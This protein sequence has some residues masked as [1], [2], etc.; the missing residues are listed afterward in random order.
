MYKSIKIHCDI[1]FKKYFDARIREYQI[2]TMGNEY[3]SGETKY[4]ENYKV[5]SK[6]IYGDKK[7]L[8]HQ[9]ED[10]S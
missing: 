9:L 8:P 10:L 4:K 6:K 2:N 1:D 7:L 5:L 3:L